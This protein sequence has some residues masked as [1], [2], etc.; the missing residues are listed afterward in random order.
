MMKIDESSLKSENQ[1]G[2]MVNDANLKNIGQRLTQQTEKKN[3]GP[4]MRSSSSL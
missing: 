3:D 4:Q 1:V 2:E